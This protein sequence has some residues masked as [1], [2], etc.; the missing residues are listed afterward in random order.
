M[1]LSISLSVCAALS[2]H[3]PVTLVPGPLVLSLVK[4][5]DKTLHCTISSCLA[6][7]LGDKRS[8]YA[9]KTG[10]LLSKW[11]TYGNLCPICQSKL[12]AYCKTATAWCTQDWVL[13]LVFVIFLFWSASLSPVL[14]LVAPVDRESPFKCLWQFQQQQPTS[15]GRKK[16]LNHKNWGWRSGWVGVGLG[17]G[18]LRSY[19]L[20]RLHVLPRQLLKWLYLISV[21]LITS[22][23]KPSIQESSI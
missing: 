18:S 23:R 13:L 16:A 1:A 12:N 11:N 22:N 14:G 2:Y 9:H 19:I 15:S 4:V 20:G 8:K 6:C 7:Q 10:H 17:E 5:C 21:V 3:R